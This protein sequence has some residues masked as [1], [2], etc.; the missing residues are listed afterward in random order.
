MFRSTKV[1]VIERNG[2]KLKDILCNKSPW[3]QKACSDE[4]CE[5]CVYSPGSCRRMNCCYKIVC[6]TCA[7]KG[8]HSVYIGETHRTWALRQSEHAQAV[9]QMNLN[10]A[11]VRHHQ[12]THP[13]KTPMFT[14]HF[15]SSYMT[16]IERQ[17]RESL[18]IEHT[19]CD[20]IMNGKGEWGAHFVPR[21]NYNSENPTFGNTISSSKLNRI[22]NITKT[23]TDAPSPSNNLATDSNT[24]MLPG[25][26]VFEAQFHQR[27][28]RKRAIAIGNREATE[29]TASEHH[30]KVHKEQQDGA[31]LATPM[32]S[33]LSGN[34]PSLGNRMQHQDGNIC[35]NMKGPKVH[36]RWSQTKLN[37]SPMNS[38]FQTSAEITRN[39][40]GTSSKLGSNQNNR[41][42]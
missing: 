17:I 19:D 28:K 23:N 10:Y 32:H 21:A 33:D 9:N 30:V 41:K 4:S 14:Y 5:P 6:T 35:S 1:H 39:P 11:I 16:S 24:S 38:N 34:I 13:D 27:K 12:E 29:S 37:F 7:V 40:T 2:S 15:I 20:M 36:V 22:G 26:S 18:C 31:K 3:R 8:V 25:N 42:S